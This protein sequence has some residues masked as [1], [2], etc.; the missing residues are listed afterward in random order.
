MVQIGL[1]EQHS[2]GDIVQTW[3]PSIGVSTGQETAFVFLWGG[4]LKHITP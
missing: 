3:V 4:G 1:S 2:P